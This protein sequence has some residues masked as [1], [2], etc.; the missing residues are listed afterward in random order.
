MADL[1]AAYTLANTDARAVNAEHETLEP[2]MTKTF[3]DVFSRIVAP[4]LT[5]AN[6]DTLVTTMTGEINALTDITA[7]EKTARIAAVQ[8]S[9]DHLKQWAT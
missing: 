4:L 7:D 2:L 1:Q 3:L 5:D 9:A 6:L 8:R